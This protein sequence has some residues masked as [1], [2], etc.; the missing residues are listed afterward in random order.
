M[1]LL[2]QNNTEEQ[3]CLFSYVE[4]ASFS[5]SCGSSATVLP[6]AQSEN[7]SS[8]GFRPLSGN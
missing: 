8:V 2:L 4:D 7:S 6:F 3:A 5:H 1:K